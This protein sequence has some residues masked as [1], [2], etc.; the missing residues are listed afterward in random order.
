MSQVQKISIKYTLKADG[1]DGEELEVT[2]EPLVFRLG[3]DEVLPVLEAHLIG[4]EVGDTS[5]FL[6]PCDQAF[7]AYDEQLI[8]KLP[9]HLFVDEDDP[10]GDM[11]EEGAIV[12]LTDQGG[13]DQPA[14]VVEI[15]NSEVTVDLNHPL[16]GEDLWYEVEVVSVD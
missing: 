14:M 3:Q 6:V 7:G 1:P 12:M 4:M 16:A 2:D 5:S 10:Q 8:R 15:G 13:E 9:K 11:F